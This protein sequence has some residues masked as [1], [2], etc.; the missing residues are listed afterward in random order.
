[1]A[2]ILPH[3]AHAVSKAGMRPQLLAMASSRAGSTAAGSGTIM[4]LDGGMGHQLKAMGI[5]I[6]GPVGS[7]R[8]FLG[9]TMAN[10]DKPQTVIDAHLAFI[11][12][13]ADFVTTN[14]YA[15]VPKCLSHATDEDL[16]EKLKGGLE[17]LVAT[18]GRLA[19]QACDMRP[20]KKVR[21][22]GSLP[23]LAESYRPDKVGP[24]EENLENYRIIAKSIAPY[25]D[26]LLCETMSTAE[27]ARAACTAASETGLPVWV[28]WTLDE[29]RPVLRS[30]E[31]LEEAV[32]ALKKVPQGEK[33]IE[34]LIFN[35]TSPEVIGKAVPMLKAL[36]PPGVKIGGY[37]N[38]FVTASSGS[39]EYRDLATNEYYKDYVSAWVSSGAEIVG[40]CCGIFPNHIAAI[41]AGLDAPSAL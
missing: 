30:G 35:C 29:I 34:G 27:E 38:G 32:A 12:A 4:L 19:R 22:A 2:A 17:E 7:M 18:A 25:A 21:V 5:E 26:V 6:S 24:F 14:S 8:R 20:E 16:Q 11:D 9:V 28:S 40:G 23:P 31:T 1:M 33:A 39:G 10:I 3:F 13:G 37:A 36:V 15:C 41:R